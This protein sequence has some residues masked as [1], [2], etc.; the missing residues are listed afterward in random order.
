VLREEDEEYQGEDFA[1]SIAELVAPFS[2]RQF[3]GLAKRR[4][5]S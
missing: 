5:T 4:I 2:R 1:R 3:P